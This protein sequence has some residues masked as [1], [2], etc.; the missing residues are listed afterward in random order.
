MNATASVRIRS[1]N[2]RRVRL[3]PLQQRVRAGDL[4]RPD[5]PIANMAHR[6]RLRVP[7]DVERFVEAFDRVVQH[8]DVLRLVLDPGGSGDDEAW[9]AARPPRRTDVG[10]VALD[11]VETWS[12]GRI[13]RLID[14]TECV[15]DSVLLRHADE[16][17]SWWL[18]I[19]HIATDAA[20]AGLVA[21]AV[22]AEYDGVDQPLGERIDGSFFET[23]AVVGAHDRQRADD[24]ESGASPLSWYGP[25]GERTSSVR[26]HEVDPLDTVS[27]AV[28]ELLDGEFRSISRDLSLLSL[29]ASA[30]AVLA[31]RFEGRSDLQ[32][33]VPL[34]HR[35]TR[36]VR[37]IV[38]PLMEIHPLTVSVQVDDTFRDVHQRTLR[39]VMDLLREAHIGTAPDRVG[40]IV[41]NVIRRGELSIGGIAVD[42]H[43]IR[44]DCIEAATMFRLHLVDSPDA[45]GAR[46][47]EIELDEND[48]F[49]PGGVGAGP[50]EHLRQ[51]F[52]AVVADP[53][54]SVGSLPIIT[55]DEVAE[56]RRLVPEAAPRPITETVP[57]AVA[58]RLTGSAG[59]VVAEHDGVTYDATEFDRW[60]SGVAARLRADGVTPGRRVG[61]CV[62]RS[63]GVLVAITAIHRLGAS[64]VMLAPAD[65]PERIAAIAA[66]ADLVTILRNEELA[67]SETTDE[68]FSA[69]RVDEWGVD[70]DLD[71]EAYVLYT[72]GST[73][74]PKGVPISH[75]GLAD[76]LDFACAEYIDELGPPAVV[77]LHS[78]LIFD[79]TITSLFLGLLSG[80]RTVVFGGTAIEALAA[81]AHDDRVTHLKAT[82][83][84]LEI[85][86]RLAP[87]TL[88]P[89]RCIVVGGE[90][91]R[92][93]LAER[94]VAACEPG[95]VV[96]NEYGPTEAV[97]GCMIHRWDPSLDIGSDV[98]VGVASAGSQLLVLDHARQLAPIGGWGEL[99]VRRAGMAQHYLGLPEQSADRFVELDT[100][101]VESVIPPDAH[102]EGRWYRTG[103]RVRVERSGVLVYGGRDDDQLKVRG[104][105]LEPGEVESA[106][107]DH[108]RVDQAFV[109]IWKPTDVPPLRADRRC[110]RC[111]LG[112]DVPGTVLA[113][114]V[115]NVCLDYDRVA[116]QAEQWF[117]TEADLDAELAEVRASHDGDIDCLH[118]LSGGKDSTYAL[119]QLV[120]RGW[121]V[122]ALTLDNGF[123]SD[124]AKEN[125]RRS[126]ADL[127]ITHEFATTES[128]NEI[129]RDSLDRYANVCQGCYKTIYTLA[130]A[131]AR[132][133]GIPVVVTGLSR[134]Q[135]FETRLIP[136]QFE[137]GR[138][139]PDAIDA[140]VLEARRVYHDTD[141][142]VTRLLPEQAVF[143]DP[144]VFDAIRFV[145]FYR[146]VDVD[147]AE[148]YSFLDAHAPWV[149]PTDTGRSTNCLINIAGIHVHKSER[150]YHNYAEPYSWDVRLGHKTLEEALEELDDP[151]DQSEVDD[152][153]GAVGYAPKQVELLTAW[154]RSTDGSDLLA[155]ELREHLRSR[156]PEHAIPAAFVRLDD[157][158]LASGTKADLSALPTPVRVARSSTDFVEPT[159]DVED[160]LC[161]I[162][163]AELGLEQVGV[164]DDFFDLGGASLAALSVVA[165]I[166]VEFGT[167]LPD[168]A[169]FRARTVRALALV[170]EQH[171]WGIDATRPIERL[172]PSVPPPRSDAEEAMLFEYRLDPSGARYNV[173]RLYTLR[174]EVGSEI[175]R[176]R[177]AE[178]V[179][180]IVMLHEPLHVTHAA[181]RT[182][183]DRESAIDVVDHGTIT[184][185]AMAGVADRVVRLAFDLDH[186]PLVRVHHGASLD[187]ECFVVIAM[188]HISIDAATFDVLWAQVAARHAGAD[189]P[190]LPIT[191]A[192][193]AAWQRERP[194]DTDDSRFWLDAATS[195]PEPRGPLFARPFPAE[196]DGYLQRRLDLDHASL[197]GPGATAFARSMAAVAMTLAGAV[198]RRRVEFGIPSSTNDHALSAD[199]VGYFLNTLPVALDAP[200]DATVAAVVAAASESVA[201]LVEHRRHPFARIV[202]DARAG[203]LTEPSVDILLAYE[204]LAAP[205]L[206]GAAVEQHN[207]S[208]GAA[209]SDCTFFVQER[210]DRLDIAVEYRGSVIGSADAG[211]LLDVFERA[212][213]ATV[214][215]PET[216]V[217]DAAVW[218]VEPDLVGL[219][220]GAEAEQPVPAQI[221]GSL[222]ADPSA[223]AVVDGDGE[224][225]A[226][227]LLVAV[228]ELVDR[229]R[230]RTGDHDGPLR[231]AV[232]LE[233]SVSIVTAML[234]VWMSGGSYVPIDPSLPA[235]RRELI[236]ATAAPSLTLVSGPGGVGSGA[237]AAVSIDRPRAAVTEAA[238]HRAVEQL[239][240][241]AT[242]V[243]IDSEAY[244]IF[245][246]GSTGQPKG[247]V[248]SHRNLAASTAARSGVYPTSPRRFLVTSSIGF[249]SSMVGL[250]WPLTTGG[251]V[252]IPGDDDVGD[253]D[254]WGAFIARTRV[255]HVLTVPSLY[256]SLLARRPERLV[257]LDTVIV[258]GEATD[259][260]LILEHHTRLAGVRLV[261]EYGPT[262]ATIWATS[263]EHRAGEPARIG[264]P[265]P[266]VTVRIV[267][268]SLHPVARGTS[269]ELLISGPTVTNGYLGD[270]A[271]TAERFVELDGRRWYRT[272]DLVRAAFEDGRRTLEFVGRVDDQLN[273]GGNRLEPVEV[274]RTLMSLDQI[275]EAAIVAGGDPVR[276]VAY[277]VVSRPG[278]FD[279]GAIRRALGDELPARSTPHRFVVVDELPRNVH[280]KVDRRALAAASSRSTVHD[281]VPM[282]TETD[283][284]SASTLVDVIVS[285]WRE[286][287]QRDDIDAESDF[288]AVGGDSL[289]AV[290]IV[291]DLGERIG[292]EVPIADLI[293]GLTPAGMARRVR[294]LEDASPPMNTNTGAAPVDGVRLI[295]MRSADP[296]DPII[297]LTAAWDDVFG[298]QALAES[299]PD[300][301]TVVALTIDPTVDVPEARTVGG[302]A[303]RA[304]ALV[305]PLLSDRRAVAVVGW[306]VGG[307]GAVDLTRRLLASGSTRPAFVG[308]IDTYFPGE[309]EH[310]WSN[311]WWKYKSMLR[312]GG[313]SAVAGEVV[314]TIRRRFG[315]PVRRLAASVIAWTGH[316]V[317]L[318]PRGGGRRSVGVPDDA[319]A[320]YE[321]DPIG[322]PVFLVVASTTNPARTLHRWSAVADHIDVASV[323]GRHRGFDSIMHAGRVDDVAQAIATRLGSVG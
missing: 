271:T 50:S 8:S 3:T 310:L 18:C 153:L 103:D 156:L 31:H 256:R 322:V 221:L 259:D 1:A 134:G 60:V 186:G 261:D 22:L 183:L 68:S 317:D 191:Y 76:Y 110:S 88:R 235:R 203:G 311:R 20:S 127:G 41:V 223:T 107:V 40:D 111:G 213:R 286:S 116:P 27:S 65:P 17:W 250:V 232:A 167:D 303:E 96:V 152:M 304:E 139:D 6:Y 313:A 165:A 275:A 66:D 115:C 215:S 32:I 222:M 58:R 284:G 185:E 179:R 290:V 252:V 35:G 39:S 300:G 289:S 47:L 194:D 199:L 205:T 208:S 78:E 143:D 268:E 71:A 177:L 293:V 278:V 55:V 61:L 315:A 234:A 171:R 86:L 117:R 43:W 195:R 21:A 298:Y 228:A 136:H 209:V 133:M 128:M 161:R 125:V 26:R 28:G 141:D 306:S 51:L 82:P 138:F 318:T 247:V 123:I 305:A 91:F 251:A 137:A 173:A 7:L 164:T 176:A 112:T 267:G 34:H 166:D 93:P 184:G 189:L 87:Q 280:G 249:D 14:P 49:R 9:L 217:G 81:V 113:D 108:P 309:G 308:L 158:E 197:A 211:R 216:T 54:A 30:C 63:V 283:A 190:E 46:R 80:G 89:L 238:V 299:F 5:E 85:L 64:F 149:R 269:G 146:Y 11:E 323:E 56:H 302:F 132:Q 230:S 33:G 187:G 83:S 270:A 295:T 159:S 147:L 155:D 90:A 204:Q 45:V 229:I 214:D 312:P 219:D 225:S 48:A 244:V 316:D 59:H 53:D 207:L 181:Q 285:V 321:V 279:E 182:R 109:R 255:S 162:W 265:I 70:V 4:L 262:E 69:A 319:I 264:E 100:D 99:W 178:A 169:V 97:V 12:T 95:V 245:T 120:Q 258:A 180:D 15:Y 140:T 243:V 19:H 297:V 227:E 237:G 157:V 129:F 201:E 206:Q 163:R 130:V 29:A 98:P 42:D 239:A 174:P 67:Y 124:G 175:D 240:A 106:L 148:L 320:R 248:V 150:G 168:A 287:L 92:R 193:H 52:A 145:D 101:L 277:I 273:V 10:D 241:A 24:T 266:G 257:G 154:Y 73:G 122:H 160:R 291:T 94:I 198:G 226:G 79:L 170:V 224:V 131:R 220:L 231:V 25:T 254:R 121:R 281:L 196:P 126:I 188:H 75:R 260:A 16:D 263:R 114:G 200:H 84:Q 233:R 62:T 301:I 74:M 288:F 57:V 314:A 276:I 294:P 23:D 296:G 292:R 242:D 202:R 151:F 142:A 210:P 144:D 104:I 218:Q 44:P 72:S 212:L 102:H 2:D 253:L 274:E 13:A 119:Y 192:E 135:F 246:S 172:D 118:L 77:A 38:G 36:S 236:L 272:G 282:G 105:R 37:R 307:I